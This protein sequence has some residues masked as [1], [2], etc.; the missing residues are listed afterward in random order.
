MRSVYVV[1]ILPS[2]RPETFNEEDQG[3][4]SIS[5]LYLFLLSTLL[6]GIATYY[7][8][9]IIANGPLGVVVGID[10]VIV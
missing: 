4:C 10:C 1:R 3:S 7:M 8:G 5:S 2:D 9:N 6:C